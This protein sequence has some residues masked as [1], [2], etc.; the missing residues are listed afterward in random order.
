[1]YRVL[2]ERSAEKDIGKTPRRQGSSGTFHEKGAG[3]CTAVSDYAT[4]GLAAICQTAEFAFEATTEFAMRSYRD[5]VGRA[6]GE[7]P[8]LV[9]VGTSG[10]PQHG[11]GRP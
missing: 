9:R 11:T 2:V 7:L 10:R 5:S 4:E 8:P 1:M 3:T 6:L